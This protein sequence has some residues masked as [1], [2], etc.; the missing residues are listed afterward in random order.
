MLY[1]KHKNSCKVGKTT[2]QERGKKEQ[3]SYPLETL[4]NNGAPA[5]SLGWNQLQNLQNNPQEASAPRDGV[6][7]GACEQK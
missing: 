2:M 4:F 3:A 7:V 6:M 5:A 1:T